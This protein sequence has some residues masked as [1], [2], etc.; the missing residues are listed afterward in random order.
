MTEKRQYY[1]SDEASA[2]I[3]YQGQG[4]TLCNTI[5]FSKGGHSIPI[6]SL[7]RSSICWPSPHYYKS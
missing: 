7:P 1:V 2:V 5:Y 6:E 4:V 3:A